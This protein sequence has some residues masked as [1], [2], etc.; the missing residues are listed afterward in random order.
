[1]RRL[2]SL[3]VA[4]ILSGCRGATAHSPSVQCDRIHE[5]SAP[6]QGAKTFEA[7]GRL[8]HGSGATV[9]RVIRSPSSLLA[10]FSAAFEGEVPADVPMLWSYRSANNVWWVGS[11]SGLGALPSAWTEAVSEPELSNPLYPF[12][13][14]CEGPD[15]GRGNG[16]LVAEFPGIGKVELVSLELIPLTPRTAS[17]ISDLV[18]R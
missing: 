11:S 16:L 12:E 3:F 7:Q 14:A 18:S 10:G 17:M 5:L 8:A 2:L 1:M 4:L 15:G 13:E 9:F 6:N